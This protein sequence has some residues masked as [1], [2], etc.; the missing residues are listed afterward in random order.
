MGIYKWNDGSEYR[1]EWD[2]N[3]IN[4]FGMYTWL[5]GRKYVG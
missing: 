2:D 1:G 3:K 5:D 4:G